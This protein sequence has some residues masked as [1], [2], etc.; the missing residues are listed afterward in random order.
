VRE[1]EFAHGRH[2]LAEKLASTRPAL[3][4]HLQEED[5]EIL[6]VCE[7]SG[8]KD[9]ATTMIYARVLNHSSVAGYTAERTTCTIHLIARSHGE[10]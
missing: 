10:A 8:P 5:Y 4:T 7:I 2:P 6:T 9:D 3:A 1:E